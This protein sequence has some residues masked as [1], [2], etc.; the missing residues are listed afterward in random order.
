MENTYHTITRADCRP[1]TAKIIDTLTPLL[2]EH[3][4]RVTCRNSTYS[5]TSI[6]A[7][8]VITIQETATGKSPEQDTFERHAAYFGLDPSNYGRTFTIRERTFTLSGLNLAARKR[9][10]QATRGGQT[11]VFPRFTPSQIKAYDLIPAP[12]T[13]PDAGGGL[14]LIN[15]QKGSA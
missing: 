4:L 9:P 12:A 1:I 7:T 8:L 3:G 14:Q 6:R 10:I 11:W 5:S 2:A 15:E 13:A